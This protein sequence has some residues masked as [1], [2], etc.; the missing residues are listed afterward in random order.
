MDLP[1]TDKFLWDLYGLSEGVGDVLDFALNPHPGKWNRLWKIQNPVF[2][3]YRKQKG[4]NSFAKLVYNLKRNGYIKV[5]GLRAKKAIMLTKEGLDK[6]LRASFKMGA[7]A[8]RKDGK[9]IMLIFDVPQKYNKSRELLRSVLR[10]LG[11]KMFQQS[12]WVTPYDVSEKTEKALQYYSL[13]KFVRIFLIE[14][15]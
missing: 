7:R 5:E 10:N 12:V 15:L 6:V 13:E 9:W 14:H 1:I 2:E 8:E 11:Y 4:R 3:K